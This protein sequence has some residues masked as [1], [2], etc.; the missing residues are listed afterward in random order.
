M[1]N[2]D[3]SL[4][5]KQIETIIGENKGTYL[6]FREEISRLQ[7]EQ[8][9]PPLNLVLCGRRGAGKTSAAKAI[10]GPE[11]HSASNSSE[12]VRNQ[13]EVCG[14]WVSLV[15]LPALDG[16]A[17]QE[18]MEESF[19]CVSLC[20][21]EGVHAFILVLPV[22]PLTDEDKGELQTIQDT[23][24]SRVND[25]TMILFTTDSDPADPDG[26]FV[27][28]NK[29]LQELLQTI[30][31]R[32]VVL[33]IKDREQIPELLETLEKN[34]SNGE[35]QSCYT[36]KTLA[37]VQMEKISQLL[38][39]VNKLKTKST[40]S[41]T[42]LR[43]VLLGGS[44]SQRNL[45]R[46]LILGGEDFT[47]E[48]NSFIKIIGSVENRQIAVINTPD[49]QFFTANKLK[50]FINECVN[51]SDPG[52]H[53]M[54]E[55]PELLTRVDLIVKENNGGHV[56]YKEFEETATPGGFVAAG[57][58]EECH[59]AE[60]LRIVLIGKTGSGKSSSGNTILGRREFKA[61]ASP[62]SVTT[63]CQEAQSEVDGRPVVVVDTPGLFDNNLSSEQVN[64]ELVKCISLV[65]PGPH[66]F[67]LVLQVGRSTPEEEKTFTLIEEVLGENYKKFT[68]ILF[69]KGDTL[70]HEEMSIQDYTE[71]KCNDVCKKLIADCGG[72]CHVFN[73]YE[74]DDKKTR[75]QVTE[76]IQKINTM[77]KKNEGSCY[78]SEMLSVRC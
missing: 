29:E 38:A 54:A 51:A 77:V 27:K 42:E 19:R 71:N 72:R 6:T 70:E 68:I 7:H 69:T 64:E 55:R 1:S 35:N 2:N 15:E 24:S 13:G 66:V 44:W 57:K 74:K 34:V 17:Q 32:Y 11:L 47:T 45:V 50:E 59:S 67:L 25:L 31:G 43:V 23:F 78:T 75:S 33:N 60:C 37:W 58:D 39:E 62:Q 76:L 8:V 41:V 12:C 30:G 48:P 26:N 10:L 22:G 63:N 53:M 16:R 3:R 18:V 46:T 40:D 21:P 20:D 49:L 9:K 36:T 14:R 56:S 65:A 28:E 52:P 61:E 73:N 5:M 4:L